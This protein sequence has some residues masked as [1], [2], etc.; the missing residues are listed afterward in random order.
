MPHALFPWLPQ[1]ASAYASQY[2]W[3]LYAVT[4]VTGV[5]TV[6]VLIVMCAFALRYRKG[7]SAPRSPRSDAEHLLRARRWIEITWITL[8]LLIFLAMAAGGAW[9]YFEH[10]APPADAMSIYVVGKQWMWK[11]EHANGKREIDEL[12][13]PRG[14]AVR[15][16][17]TSQDVIHSFFLPAFRIKQDVLPGRYTELWFAA[18]RTGDF[19][20]FCAEYC[21][22]AHSHMIGRVVVMEPAEF[23][24]WLDVG[25]PRESMAERGAGLFRSYGCSGCHGERATVHAP[26][27]EGLFGRPVPLEGGAMVI[28]DERY[29]RDSILQPKREIAAGY[30][31]IMPSFAGRIGEEDLLDLIAYVRSLGRSQGAEP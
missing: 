31:P 9:L 18:N 14:R 16:A 27:L 26:K 22:T 20:L 3:L 8:P 13:V 1:E 15:L 11:L 19:H 28:A 5:V 21:G 12:H 29:V 30:P 17:M 10:F 7:S 4:A 25:A 23:A 2:D 6:G 24:A